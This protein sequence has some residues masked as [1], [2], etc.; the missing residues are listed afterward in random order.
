VI[1]IKEIEFKP[2][3]PLYI[4]IKNYIREKIKSGAL[5]IGDK[6]SPEELLCKKFQVSKI[7]VI[8]ALRDLVN[9]G[10][11]IRKQGKGSFVNKHNYVQN[12][13]KFLDFTCNMA[14]I[15]AE[16]KIL[17]WHLVKPSKKILN[18]MGLSKN[19]IVLEIIRLRYYD[20]KVIG[21]E[22]T[23]ISKIISRY[24]ENKK[25]LFEKKFTYDIYK[26]IPDIILN[27]SKIS[28]KPILANKLQAK[29]LG[30][31]IGDPILSQERITFSK[32]KKVIEITIFFSVSNYTY[33]LNFYK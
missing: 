21:L 32:N 29:N 28:L 9:E 16:H 6:I 22:Y 1:K 2:D 18:K 31:K 3:V 17:K 20:K 23:Y 8:R 15:E 12:L 11:I 19:D 4:Q 33:C 27:N 10:L 5:K 30:V 26:T 7:T 14:S 25:N 13:N 24:F